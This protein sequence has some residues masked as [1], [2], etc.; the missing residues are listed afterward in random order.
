MCSVTLITT[1]H[2][3]RGN[4]NSNELYQIVERIA[5]DVIF[6]EMSPRDF[7][8]FYQG[9]RPD[10]LETKTI[11]L[12]LQKSGIVHFPVDLDG[13]DLVNM[14]L[15]HEIMEM[16]DMSYKSPEYND[17]ANQL[18]NLAERFGFKYLNGDQFRTLLKRKHSLEEIILNIVNR[19]WPKLMRIKYKLSVIGSIHNSNYHLVGSSLASIGVQIPI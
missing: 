7:S 2:K 15:K 4:C 6:E 18:N 5:P 13:N 12:Y 16:F 17:L 10:S 3:E 9:G 1:G 8:A 14:G 11:K 19:T